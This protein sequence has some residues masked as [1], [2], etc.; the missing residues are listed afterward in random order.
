MRQLVARQRVV[1]VRNEVT[2]LLRSLKN[3][4]MPGISYDTAWIASHS[5]MFPKSLD[6]ILSNQRDDGSWG[7]EA[8][9]HH[10]RLIS[11]L[12]SIVTLSKSH[13]SDRFKRQ[14]EKGEEYL[15][16][17][18][19]EVKKEEYS[20]I[21]FELLFPTLMEEAERLHLNA[22]HVGDEYF[23]KIRESKLSVILKDLIYSGKTTLSFSAEFLGQ[24]LDV[25]RIE[26]M[27]NPNGSVGNSPSATA[28]LL[29]NVLER[30]ALAYLDKVSA[31]NSDGSIMAVYPF[32]VFEKSWAIYHFITL[33]LP[34]EEY[35]SKHVSDLKQAWTK[36]GTGISRT[37]PVLDSDDTALAFR[38]LTHMGE[39]LS[40]EVFNNYEGERNFICFKYERDPS[41][42][43][44]IHI[45]DAIKN[46][47]NCNNRE[48]S[49][50][51]ILEFL[52][53][54]RTSDGYWTDKWHVS[55]YYA[56]GHAIIALSGLDDSIAGEAVEW[57][58]DS[59]NSNGSWGV[60]RETIEE[61]AYALW[62]LLYYYE[63]VEKID[64]KI[65]LN[66]IQYLSK[67]L[68]S[69]DY[70]ELW[71]AKGLYCPLNVVKS[72]VLSVLYKSSLMKLAQPKLTISVTT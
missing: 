45:L 35:C 9:Y 31:L 1:D 18:L 22:P 29:R 66:G 67:N 13:K 14:I 60:Y 23:E 12:A 72:A 11:T 8:E 51:K 42:S 17:T 55:P 28:Y 21:G 7:C 48:H 16:Q 25:T 44:N 3:G 68:N 64:E 70:P 50:E 2:K 4:W 47:P 40:S 38:V 71:I 49:I 5:L 46:D 34:I 32:E 53:S 39:K 27:Q 62:A 65:I 58:I 19:N 20:T 63:N 10:D 24:D 36:M 26:S 37:S 41:V 33:G 54:K 6:W 61:T 57:I 59:Q 30:K 15:W 43:A 52:K 56:T 69:E